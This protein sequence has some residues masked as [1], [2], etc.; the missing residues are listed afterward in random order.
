MGNYFFISSYVLVLSILLAMA[1]ACR[2]WKNFPLSRIIFH[3]NALSHSHPL[4][5][6]A[7]ISVQISTAHAQPPALEIAMFLKDACLEHEHS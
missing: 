3:L 2:R 4:Y 1:H 7:Q 5:A 6:H